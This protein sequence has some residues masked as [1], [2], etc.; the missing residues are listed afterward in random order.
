MDLLLTDVAMRGTVLA[1]RMLECTPEMRI[2]SGYSG[3]LEEQFTHA[4][5]RAGEVLLP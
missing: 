1:K 3:L 4:R 2:V 5:L